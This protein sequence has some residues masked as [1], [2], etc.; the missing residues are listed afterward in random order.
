MLRHPY[1]APPIRNF[2]ENHYEGRADLKRVN[3]AT[4][5]VDRCDACGLVFQ[6]TIP[7]DS[8]IHEIYDHWI[9]SSEQQRRSTRLEL[10]D[11]RY[12]SGQVEFLIQFF[13]RK[14][15]QLSFF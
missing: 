12:L 8:L 11:Y 10:S 14:P 7:S 15:S 3:G 5:E 2:L 9:P 4:F 13:K 1:D 6:R